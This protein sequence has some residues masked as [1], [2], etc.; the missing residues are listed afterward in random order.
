MRRHSLLLLTILALAISAPVK[1]QLVT[2]SASA[3]APQ[4]TPDSVVL[5]GLQGPLQALLAHLTPSAHL[6]GLLDLEDGRTGVADREEKLWVLVEARRAMAP[7]HGVELLFVA[8][9]LR[10]VRRPVP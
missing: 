8:S 4:A 10:R 7:I 5:T 6:L 2:P 3:S 9:G 1:A